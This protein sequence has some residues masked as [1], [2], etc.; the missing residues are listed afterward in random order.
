MKDKTYL[1][2]NYICH[3]CQMTITNEKIFYNDIKISNDTTYLYTNKSITI[4][5][6]YCLAKNIVEIY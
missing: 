1:H 6:P 2:I 4:H 5:C 3:N